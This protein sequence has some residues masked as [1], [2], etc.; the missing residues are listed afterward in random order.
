MMLKQ[1]KSESDRAV[2]IIDLVEK[3]AFHREKNSSP[4]PHKSK[5]RFVC[6]QDGCCGKSRRPPK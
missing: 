1:A 3:K 5:K 2:D 6:S 4:S